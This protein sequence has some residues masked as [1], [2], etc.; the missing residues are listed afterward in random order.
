MAD[1]CTPSARGEYLAGLFTDEG[2]FVAACRAARAEGRTDLQAWTP[3][4]VH[5]LEEVLGLDRSWIGR[6]VLGAT[7]CGLAFCF[8]LLFQLTVI[9]WPVIYGGKPYFT[10]QLW[11]VPILELGLL[12]G[13]VANLKLAFFTCRLLPEPGTKL[14]SPRMSD[15]AF[16]LALPVGEG[17]E[18][19]LREHGATGLVSVSA[20]QAS[21]E[22]EFSC[23]E[24]TPAE[25]HHA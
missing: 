16:A 10:W 24:A 18:A 7:A 11:V 5:G 21:G 2:A 20:A 23:P 25:A 8:V 9:D 12:L 3:W 22:P 6:G 4:P 13:A 19:W 17:V 15:D 14:P 1:V